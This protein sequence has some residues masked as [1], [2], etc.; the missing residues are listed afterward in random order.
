MLLLP[1][2]HSQ[3]LSP[4]PR[5]KPALPLT[6]LLRPPRRGARWP[7]HQHGPSWVK[8]LLTFCTLTVPE[9]ALYMQ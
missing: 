2:L 4:H 6:P 1:R 5:A 9:S 3:D 7:A 8:S